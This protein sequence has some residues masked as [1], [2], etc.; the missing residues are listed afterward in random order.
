MSTISGCLAFASAM[1]ASWGVEFRLG[2]TPQMANRT[3]GPLGQG[4]PPA[5]IPGASA[6]RSH[7][8]WAR[9]FECPHIAN[10]T[11]GRLSAPWRRRQH[12]R[13]EILNPDR[14]HWPLANDCFDHCNRG[15]CIEVVH[16]AASVN[17]GCPQLLVDLALD[18]HGLSISHPKAANQRRWP[19]VANEQILDALLW[20]LGTA[21]FNDAISKFDDINGGFSKEWCRF[22]RQD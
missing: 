6:R 19:F 15:F 7:T 8:S 17:V 4:N 18:L 5:A 22:A 14:F 12:F 11:L 2:T 20:I 21:D 9:L 1:V 10:V 13:R 3:G 16:F